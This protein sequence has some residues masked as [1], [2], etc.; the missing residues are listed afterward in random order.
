MS[1]FHDRQISIKIESLKI[2][3]FSIFPESVSTFQRDNYFFL[4]KNRVLADAR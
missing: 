4:H 3:I 2:N 1:V